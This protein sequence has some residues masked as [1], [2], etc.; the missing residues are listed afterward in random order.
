ML[1][2]QCHWCSSTFLTA[3]PAQKYCSMLCRTRECPTCRKP[4]VL[5]GQERTFCSP[6]CRPRAGRANPNFGNRRPGMFQ[7]SEEF[8]TRLSR[9]RQGAGNPNWRGGGPGAGEFGQQDYARRWALQHIGRHCEMCGSEAAI[10]VH[11]I[12]A[13]RLFREPSL[14]NFRENLMVLCR[15]HHRQV[16]GNRWTQKRSPRE[17]PFVDRLPASILLAL[18]QDG[19]VSSLPE[20]IRLIQ[21]EPTTPAKYRHEELAIDT[22]ASPSATGPSA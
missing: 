7:H 17:I 20:D 2:K 6:K 4:F 14:A 1:Q 19:L 16:D 8:R 12:A 22:A 5:A 10:E 21:F 3:S 13:R 9:E 18:E 11:H 15:R